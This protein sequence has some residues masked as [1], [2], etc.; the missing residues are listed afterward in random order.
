MIKL[1]FSGVLL[2]SLLTDSV[3]ADG[4]LLHFNRYFI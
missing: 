2:I 1:L 3:R 4:K